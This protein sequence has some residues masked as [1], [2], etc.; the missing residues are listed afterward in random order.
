[1]QVMLNFINRSEAGRHPNVL[2]FQRN[3][4]DDTNISAVAWKV[5]RNCGKGC[6]HPFVYSTEFEIGL[7]DEFG[8]Y[9]PRLRAERGSLFAVLPCA[10]GRHLTRRGAAGNCRHIVLKNELPRGAVNAN[11]YV[12]GR[13]MATKTS[14][15]PGQNAVFEFRPTLSIGIA[16]QVE[17]GQTVAAAAIDTA[18]TE[19]PLFGLAGADIVMSGSGKESR[20]AQHEFTL[21]NIKR[22]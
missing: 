6:T 21:E 4:T 15:A 17:E 5:I 9:S 16:P 3:A 22:I 13:L 2:I 18:L 20:T 11:I 10:V 12:S 14:V 8:N 19:L 7:G 1:M